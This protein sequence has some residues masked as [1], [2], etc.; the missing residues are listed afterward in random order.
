MQELLIGTKCG[1]V[2]FRF[3]F[4]V[5]S[6][7]TVYVSPRVLQAL[8]TLRQPWH[9][10]NR[11]SRYPLSGSHVLLYV[12]MFACVLSRTHLDDSNL[13]FL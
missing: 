5:P 6:A 9:S 11:T 2:Q 7:A 12:F 10:S 13:H 3:F 1:A 8:H 4:S